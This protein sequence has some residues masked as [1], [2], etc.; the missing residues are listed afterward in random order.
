MMRVEEHVTHV[1]IAINVV[2]STEARKPKIWIRG[3]KASVNVDN[4][5]EPGA[6]GKAITY[7][8][9]SNPCLLASQY[10]KVWDTRNVPCVRTLQLYSVVI[11]KPVISVANEPKQK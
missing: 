11:L 7:E 2:A 9:Y 3:A 8:A 10:I 1:L 4:I 5:N 6:Q